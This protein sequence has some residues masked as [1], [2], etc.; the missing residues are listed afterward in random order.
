ML[1]ACNSITQTFWCQAEKMVWIYGTN[2]LQKENELHVNNQ[3]DTNIRV[4][5]YLEREKSLQ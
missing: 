5:V 1:E 2:V 3:E 4:N